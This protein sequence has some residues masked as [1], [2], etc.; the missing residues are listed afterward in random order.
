MFDTEGNLAPYACNRRN[1]GLLREIRHMGARVSTRSDRII[2]SGAFRK[3]MYKTQVFIGHEGDLSDKTN[4][5]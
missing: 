4:T 1:E 5:V 3:L 2:H